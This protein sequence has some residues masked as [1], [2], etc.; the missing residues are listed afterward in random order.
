MEMLLA[1]N[2]DDL[3]T[4]SYAETVAAEGEV[5]ADLMTVAPDRQ[6]IWRVL[7]WLLESDA[8]MDPELMTVFDRMLTDYKTKARLISYAIM[9]ER[10]QRIVEGA[11]LEREIINELRES[12]LYMKD[13]SKVK[14]LAALGQS[15]GVGLE[16]LDKLAGVTDTPEEILAALGGKLKED[17]SNPLKDLRPEERENIRRVLDKIRKGVPFVQQVDE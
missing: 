3:K 14:L 16:N 11:D 17:A 4:R 2:F 9:R 1:T 13:E 8:T 10:L 15:I 5:P 6:T 7:S 12:A